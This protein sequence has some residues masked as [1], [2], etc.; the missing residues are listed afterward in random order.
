MKSKNS[1]KTR[2]V[3]K[4]KSHILKTN[5]TSSKEENK[6]KITEINDH[7]LHENQEENEIKKEEEEEDKNVIKPREDFLKK[8]INDMNI[9]KNILN[10]VSNGLNQQLK[11]IEDDMDDNQI[12][13]TEVSKNVN[14]L[15]K[16][17]NNNNNKKLNLIEKKNYFHVIK[18][19]N[20]NK[21]SLEKNLLKLEESEK[22]LNNE[23]Y[24]SLDKQKNLI[25]ENIKEEKL[26]NIKKKTRN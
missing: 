20:K 9:N 7:T 15:I 26:K 14:N 4:K 6:N 1:K 12:L 21:Q 22:L 10:G 11:Y 5:K 2:S 13:I 19:L 16:N 17:D 8:K 23:M 25:E 18:E 3:D 24:S